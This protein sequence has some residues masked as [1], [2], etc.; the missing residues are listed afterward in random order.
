MDIDGEEI[1]EEMERDTIRRIRAAVRVGRLQEPF[2]ASEVNKVLGIH[3]A[4]T[5]LPKH[6][7][8]NPDSNTELFVRVERGRYR[9]VSR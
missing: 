8:G 4:G 9:L 3:W 6:R 7:V 5:F 2:K 1:E